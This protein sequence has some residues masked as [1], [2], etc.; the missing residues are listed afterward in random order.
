ML[1][2]YLGHVWAM[3]GQ[4]S[5]HVWA[6]FAPFV[7][8]CLDIVWTLC[9]PCL[10]MF[11]PCLDYV[12]TMF[13]PCFCH[14]LSMF[15]PGGLT[16]M[17]WYIANNNSCWG[18]TRKYRRTSDISSTSSISATSRAPLRELLLA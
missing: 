12:W 15:T 9:G 6:V 16:Y 3:F 10:G 7:G 11:G 8:P 5:D 18:H 17:Y 1:G 14:D 13:G 2:L 4:C